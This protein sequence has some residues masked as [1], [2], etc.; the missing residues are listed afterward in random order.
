MAVN[1]FAT[2]Y[3]WWP[4]KSPLEAVLAFIP[5]LYKKLSSN[6]I[7]KKLNKDDQSWNMCEAI[8]F[9]ILLVHEY[10]QSCVT[11]RILNAN[12]QLHSLLISSLAIWQLYSNR[13]FFKGCK[14]YLKW[15]WKSETKRCLIQILL[16]HSIEQIT[17]WL[18]STL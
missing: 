12:I 2:Q 16:N 9:F 15:F 3:C 11:V 17:F 4:T 6:L 10:V 14:T 7:A 13:R 5:I 18:S 1:P 8:I